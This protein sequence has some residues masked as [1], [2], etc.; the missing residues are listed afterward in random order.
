MASIEV[1][2][3][4]TNGNSVSASW[5]LGDTVAALI[6]QFGEDVIFSHVKRSLII[7]V[8]AYMRGMLDAEKSPEEIQKAVADWK[9]GLR[10]AAKSPLE[11]A[12]DEISRMSPADRAALAKE[13][14]A[15]AN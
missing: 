2:A 3:E 4:R 11:R 10:K 15:R 7:A 14:R 6:E 12:R 8:Q 1:K 13:I 9:P 5:E